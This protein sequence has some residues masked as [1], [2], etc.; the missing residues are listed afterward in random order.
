[1]TVS[2]Q[3]DEFFKDQPARYSN[4]GDFSKELGLITTTLKRNPIRRSNITLNREYVIIDSDLK[5]NGEKTSMLI[6]KGSLPANRRFAE[7]REKIV[8]DYT[9]STNTLRW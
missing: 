1:M 7:D 4:S 3:H 6:S 5:A 8:E 9:S 2:I